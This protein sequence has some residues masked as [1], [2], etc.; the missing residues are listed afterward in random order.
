MYKKALSRRKKIL[1]NLVKWENSKLE[2][3]KNKNLPKNY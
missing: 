2:M 1:N 3:I